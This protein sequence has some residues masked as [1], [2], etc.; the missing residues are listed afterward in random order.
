M[1][2]ASLPALVDTA[3]GHNKLQWSNYNTISISTISHAGLYEPAAVGLPMLE[4]WAGHTSSI[5][6]NL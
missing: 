2:H 4:G 6:I 3:R 5:D 1:V